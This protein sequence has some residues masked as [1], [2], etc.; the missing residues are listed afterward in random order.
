MLCVVVCVV[1]CVVELLDEVDE[2]EVE[3]VEIV[4]K[5]EAVEIVD[6]DELSAEGTIT[7]TEFEP[8]LAT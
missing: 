5:D 7:E 6:E 1:V 2:D 8:K 3:A 4:E